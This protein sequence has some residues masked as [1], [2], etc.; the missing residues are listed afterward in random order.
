MSC[1]AC[2]AAPPQGTR[3]KDGGARWLCLGCKGVNDKLLYQVRKQEYTGWYVSLSAED[4]GQLLIG[5]RSKWLE[6]AHLL[7]DLVDILNERHDGGGGGPPLP[8]AQPLAAP[9]WP[10]QPPRPPPPPHGG[11]D[12]NIDIE[13]DPRYELVQVVKTYRLRPY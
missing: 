2:G 13:S 11:G 1:R 8:V 3:L 10:P 5:F 6:R 4:K 9:V 12:P 7:C